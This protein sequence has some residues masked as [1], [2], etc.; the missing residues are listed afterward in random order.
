MKRTSENAFENAIE[1]ILLASGFNRHLSMDFD[2]D[3]A[4][5]PEVAISFIRQTQKKV[6]EKLETLHGE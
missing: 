1:D 5:F 3:R 4:L 6:W 2:R